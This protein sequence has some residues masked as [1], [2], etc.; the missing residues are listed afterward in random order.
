MPEGRTSQERFVL[1]GRTQNLMT[2]CLLK[3][4]F[5]V[6]Y[7]T[8]SMGLF[9]KCK[10]LLKA[11]QYTINTS[12]NKLLIADSFLTIFNSESSYCHGF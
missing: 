8:Q 7:H 3:L 10:D 2:F 11:Q 5:Y 12:S 6:R 4:K 9:C 1:W